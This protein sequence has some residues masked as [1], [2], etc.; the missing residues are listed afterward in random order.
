MRIALTLM[1]LAAAAAWPS[2]ASAFDLEAELKML[3]AQ[4]QGESFLLATQDGMSLSQ[5]IE[6]VRKR[7]GGK[8]L[9]AETKIQGGREVHHIKVL[10]KDGKVRTHRVNGRR[11]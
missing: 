2:Q 1:V 10:T 6:S 8:V 4:Y 3:H 11:R 7:T 9:S 5:A